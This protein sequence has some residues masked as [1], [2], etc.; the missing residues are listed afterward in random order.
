MFN[1]APFSHRRCYAAKGSR[2]CVLF[3]AARGRP[4]GGPLLCINGSWCSHFHFKAILCYNGSSCEEAD[5]HGNRPQGED[6]HKRTSGTPRMPNLCI[7]RSR[8][9]LVHVSV[10][11]GSRTNS[12]W[13]W[14]SL[15]HWSG[16]FGVSRAHA[17]RYVVVCNE[18]GEG[19]DVISSLLSDG[20]FPWQ[21][22]TVSVSRFADGHRHKKI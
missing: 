18:L 6:I 10:P 19:S 15:S 16:D 14:S 1:R 17:C 13:K 2:V 9:G 21:C 12:K 20:T 5:E 7:R 22:S 11:F 3:R 4:T 8:D